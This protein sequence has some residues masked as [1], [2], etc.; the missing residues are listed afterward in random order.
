MKNKLLFFAI[1]S[2][3]LA[4]GILQANAQWTTQTMSLRQGW[5]AVY[6][7][8][9]ASYDTLN[10]LVGEGAQVSTPITEIWL[11][12]PSISTAQFVTT[13]QSPTVANSQWVSWKRSENDTSALQRLTGNNAYLVYSTAAFDWSL[14]GTPV[15]PS[16]QWT[17]SGLNLIGFPTPTGKAPLFSDFL[18]PAP[19]LRQNLEL[20]Q[21]I[22]G[23][24]GANNPQQVFS[25]RGTSVTRGQAFWIRSDASDNHYFGPLELTMGTSQDLRFSDSRGTCSFRVKNLTSSQITFT[26]KLLESETAPGS[27]GTFTVPPLLLRGTRNQTNLTYNYT[28]FT[29]SSTASWTLAASGN[30]GSQVEIVLGLNRY[31][32]TGNVGDTLA[33][34][35]RI[36]DS[37]G[38]SQIDLPISATIASSAGLWVGSASVNQV[39]NYLKTYQTDGSTNLVVDSTGKY[40]TE[41]F[42][43]NLGAV[44]QPFALRLI[45][46]NPT[47][48]NATLLQ[49]VYCG[50]DSQTNSIVATSESSLSS[51]FFSSARRISAPHLPWTADN[52]GWSFNNNLG[53]NANMSVSVNLGYNDQ[54]SNPFVHTYHPDHDNLDSTFSQV[55]PQGTESY[56]IRRNITLKVQAPS[57]DFSSLTSGSTTFSGAYLENIIIS[58]LQRSGGTN[59]SRTFHVEGTFTL[60]RISTNSILT[61]P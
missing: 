6:L 28:N 31:A 12:Q 13:P 23:E 47:N 38:L 36:T 15:A 50:L 5:N 53:R 7:H 51:S 20:F 43:T 33:A 4:E 16:Y 21:Y 3:I 2:V 30:T 42:D 60:N 32:T 22:G 40:V 56:S 59:D 34:I 11:W 26:I 44:P 8:V 49:R 57:D 25:L 24:L 48:G 9:N 52:S 35:L 19:A 1:T 17:S 39:G 61:T 27:S 18:A 45:V 29:T 41:S 37:L 54:A 46:H 10:N 55:L 14:K 58:G